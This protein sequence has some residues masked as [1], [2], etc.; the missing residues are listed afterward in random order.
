MT[1]IRPRNWFVVWLCFSF[2]GCAA[3]GPDSELSPDEQL[4]DLLVACQ[5]EDGKFDAVR[6]EQARFGVQRVAT[7]YPGHVPSQVAAAALAFENGEA[8]RAQGFVDRALSLQPDH[9]EARVLRVRIAVDDGGLDLA[10]RL[11]DDGLR[12]RPD[13]FALYESS[14]WVHQLAGEPAEAMRAL[15]TAARLDAP[16]W[17]IAYHRGLVEEQRGAV[18]AARR[19][20]EAALD[21]NGDCEAAR[22]RLAGLKARR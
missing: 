17:R 15:D 4:H 13:A 20:Y 14:A 16:D 7:K 8:Q 19:H 3:W 6:V 21:A 12:L 1:W 22:R 11:V 10:R 9:V 5:D 18:E 2:S